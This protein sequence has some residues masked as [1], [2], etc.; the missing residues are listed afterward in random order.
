MPDASLEAT[1]LINGLILAV[2]VAVASFGLYRKVLQNESWRSE[3]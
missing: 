3:K 2:L 1:M